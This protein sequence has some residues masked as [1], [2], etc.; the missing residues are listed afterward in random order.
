MTNLDNST[1]RRIANA[2]R[3]LSMDAVE[4]AK[5][6]HPGMPM[7]MADV[8]TILFSEF[9]HF[10][11]NNPHWPNRDR[12]ILSAGHGSMLLYSLLYLTGYKDITIED[13][14]QF[15]QLHAKTAG[16]PEYGELAAIETTTGPLGQGFANSIGMAIA[17]KLT[18]KR[19][20]SEICDHKIY[21]IAGDGCLMEGISHEAASLAGHLKLGNLVVLY[22]DNNISIDGPTDLTI[23]ENTLKRFKAYG[24]FVRNIDGHNYDEIRS[25]LLEAQNTELPALIACKTTIAYG[26][27]TK[28]GTEAAHGAPLGEKEI[29]EARKELNWPYAPFEIPPDILDKWRE[30]GAKGHSLYKKWEER[31]DRLSPE[32]QQEYHRLQKGELPSNLAEIFQNLKKELHE[33]KPQQATRKSS[34]IVLNKIAPKLP[35]LLGGSADLSGSNETKASMMEIVTRDNFAGRYIHY[36]VRE[37]AMAAIM[38]GLALY[39]NFIPYGGSFLVFTDYCRPAIRLSALMKLRVIYVM[40]HDS[41]GLGEDGPTHQPIEHL[42]SLRAIPNLLVLR[43]R[44]S[45]V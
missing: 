17:E 16:H 18:E 28:G 1:Y 10:D 2:I 25:A 19:F 11:P 43:D 35:E 7:G 22:D 27:P 38:N 12:F 4:Q 42:A 34:G 26:A 9:L 29:A 37:H 6:G 32:Q 33:T 8:A 31:F 20:G 13:I 45:V 5:S 41:I 30:I 40:T 15:R 21:T 14:K 24:W 23:S 39:K 3:A 44:K 36:G